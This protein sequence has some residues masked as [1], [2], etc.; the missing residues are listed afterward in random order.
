MSGLH[1]LK[2]QSQKGKITKRFHIAICITIKAS[3]PEQYIL[4]SEERLRDITVS[5][6]IQ[7]HDLHRTTTRS[8]PGQFLQ[9]CPRC[10]Q[11]TN[12]LCQTIPILI[13]L[14]E[15]NQIRRQVT[16]LQPP[17]RSRT[18]SI[19]HRSPIPRPSNH[20]LLPRRMV[21]ILQHRNLRLPENPTFS[22][23]QRRKPSRHHS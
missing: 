8:C 6:N 17:E 5:L 13:R 10:H 4:V 2:R 22:K 7:R 16:S 23:S 11:N 3:Q 14:L 1:M 20:N 12:Q 18:A 19:K 21:S 15:N 9:K